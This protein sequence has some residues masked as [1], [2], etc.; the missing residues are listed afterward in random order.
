MKNVAIGSRRQLICIAVLL[1]LG[2]SARAASIT[3]FAPTNSYRGYEA[4]YIIITGT[5]F[6]GTTNPDERKPG[7]IFQCGLRHQH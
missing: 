5:D 1:M 2:V 3:S 7:A 4:L 6:T